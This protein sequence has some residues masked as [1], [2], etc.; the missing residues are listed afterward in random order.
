MDNHKLLLKYRFSWCHPSLSEIILNQLFTS[1]VFLVFWSVYFI[2]RKSKFYKETS[3]SILPSWFCW[4]FPSSNAG[5]NL[6]CV[7]LYFKRIEVLVSLSVLFLATP[8]E[9]CVNLFC[10]YP[11]N[12]VWY[13]LLPSL[14]C[15]LCMTL[16]LRVLF[17]GI[18]LVRIPFFWHQRPR[19]LEVS[20]P[21]TGGGKCFLLPL[22]KLLLFLLSVAR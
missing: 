10:R 22:M 1:A 15:Y 9:L 4:R 6:E 19:L 14:A 11:K 8:Y 17:I 3:W 5:T 12:M 2:D 20:M 7:N 16:S 13:M 18:E 21:S